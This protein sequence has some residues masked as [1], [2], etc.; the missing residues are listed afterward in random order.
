MRFKPTGPMFGLTLRGMLFITALLAIGMAFVG[1]KVKRA[2]DERQIADDIVRL[3]GSVFRTVYGMDART[4]AVDRTWFER[5]INLDLE[6]RIVS[7]RLHGPEVTDAR[8]AQL[9]GLGHLVNLDL[10]DTPIDG[11]GLAALAHL[12]TLMGIEL[13]NNGVCNLSDEGLAALATLPPVYQLSIEVNATAATAATAAG[14]PSQITDAGWAAIGRMESLR[15]LELRGQRVTD[16]SLRQLKGLQQLRLLNT[17]ISDAGLE[18]IAKA[19]PR[20]IYLSIHGGSIS[21][22][23]LAHLRRCQQLTQLQISGCPLTDAGIASISELQQL[24]SLQLEA[25][26]TM[27]A[28]GLRPIAALPNLTDLTLSGLNFA[29][30]ATA[31]LAQLT[32]LN[33][34]NLQSLKGPFTDRALPPLRSL[35][36]LRQLDLSPS[37]TS[38]GG[39]RDLQKALPDLTISQ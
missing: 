16:A 39:L 9:A 4:G 10:W 1:T 18:A 19:L 11:T 5:L 3:G 37:Q 23:G 27:T 32:S 25:G 14:P 15:I 13:H 24:Q 36:S 38:A 22:S 8:L 30:E 6:A 17:R 35:K 31:P 20:L 28:D 33:Q 21:G 34:L 12:P 26:T 2:R 7:V 29:D